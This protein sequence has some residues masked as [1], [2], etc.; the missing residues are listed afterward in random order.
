MLIL[1]PLLAI[2]IR[3]LN[4]TAGVETAIKESGGGGGGGGGWR[5]GGLKIYSTQ[6][7]TI[8]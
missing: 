8:V 1:R 2:E 6:K 4:I 7:L 5:V 3:H